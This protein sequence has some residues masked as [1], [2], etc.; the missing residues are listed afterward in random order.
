MKSIR[1]ADLKN[2]RVLVR[3]DFNVPLSPQGGIVDDARIKASLAT[4]KYLLNSKAQ[5][6]I[7]ISHLGR[8]VIR[9]K[10]KIANIIAGNQNLSLKPVAKKLA[11]WLKVKKSNFI[12]SNLEGSPLPV[13]KILPKLYLMENIRF[14]AEE[15][16]NDLELGKTLAGLG[17]VFVNDAFAV[18]HRTHTSTVALAEQLPSYAGYLIQK[19][20]E[21][22]SII[23][24]NPP[25]PFVVVLGGA[26]ISDKIMVIKHLLKKVDFFLLGGVMAN[27]FL[28]SRNIEMKNSV[29]EKD[30]VEI[31]KEL[32][33]RASRKI[34]LP[35]DL[36]W[37][38]GRI[39]DVGKSA[40]EQYK[41]YLDKAKM[42]FMNGTMGLTSLGL[43]KYGLGTTG[44]IKNIIE[45]KGAMKIISG[46][47]TV[48]EVNK[49]KLASKFDFVSTGGGATLKF[50]AGEKLPGLEALK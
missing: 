24:K 28:A 48:A 44:M 30:R 23:L 50:L 6:V 1:D 34:I 42:I 20:V 16:K 35:V 11:E 5:R 29:V 18:C 36:L 27:T 46:G 21:N 39:V 19:E 8:P 40:L 7:L 22:L 9:S 3:V 13:Y 41:R 38:R 26:K 47:D 15:A 12:Y 32:M 25:H 14:L 33:D 17:D 49:L 43:K 10:E 4:V 45:V 2:K 31:A 37:E